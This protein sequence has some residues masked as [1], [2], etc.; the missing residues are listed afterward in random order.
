MQCGFNGGMEIFLGNSQRGMGVSGK[1][2]PFK[3]YTYI[4]PGIYDSLFLGIIYIWTFEMGYSFVWQNQFSDT[5]I[6]SLLHVPVV[7]LLFFVVIQINFGVSH[8]SWW[9]WSFMN[10]GTQ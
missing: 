7:H 4:L 10:T 8:S 9:T 5:C 1:F 3:N 2:I 6:K